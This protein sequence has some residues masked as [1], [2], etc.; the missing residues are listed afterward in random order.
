MDIDHICKTSAYNTITKQT[1]QE[2]KDDL[3]NIKSINVNTV[4]IIIE[5]NLSKYRKLH[6]EKVNI[7]S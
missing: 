4:L 2:C 1:K 7:L 5:K 6:T 3:I